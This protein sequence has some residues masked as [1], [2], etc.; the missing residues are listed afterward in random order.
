MRLVVVRHV[1]WLS[2]ENAIP[3]DLALQSVGFI[4]PKTACA[5]AIQLSARIARHRWWRLLAPPQACRLRRDSYASLPP[6]DAP[7]GIS[8]AERC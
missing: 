1:R 8:E 3:V 2:V 5:Q 7:G 4:Q 6:L